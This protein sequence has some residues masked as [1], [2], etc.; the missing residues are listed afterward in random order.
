MNELEQK[1]LLDYE[2]TK[3][4]LNEDIPSLI[5]KVLELWLE[6]D[7][8][9]LAIIRKDRINEYRSTKKSK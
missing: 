2:I 4:C 5:K 1:I 6:Y 3:R 9:L 7:K 8:E